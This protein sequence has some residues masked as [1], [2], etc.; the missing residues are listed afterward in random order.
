MNRRNALGGT[1]LSVAAEEGDTPCVQML[2]RAGGNVN[3][4]DVLDRA[5]LTEAVSNGH[6]DCAKELIA[7]GASVRTTLDKLRCGRKC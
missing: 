5:A 6:V 7:A 2:L 3:I 4:A 1:A